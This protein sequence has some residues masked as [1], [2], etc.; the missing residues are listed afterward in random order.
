[1]GIMEVTPSPN[2]K[3][4][5]KIQSN[6]PSTGCAILT[7]PHLSFFRQVTCYPVALRLSL[8]KGSKTFTALWQEKR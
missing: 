5:N 2:K 6:F 7:A 8:P 3:L 1:M 4:H